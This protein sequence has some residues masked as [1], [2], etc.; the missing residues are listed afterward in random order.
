MPLPCMH[1]LIVT[2][3]LLDNTHPSLARLGTIVGVSTKQFLAVYS[4][5]SSHSGA[6]SAAANAITPMERWGHHIMG[7]NFRSSQLKYMHLS[8]SNLLYVSLAIIILRNPDNFPDER[9][10]NS[11]PFRDPHVHLTHLCRMTLV[12]KPQLSFY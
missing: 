12:M 11:K 7:S 6:A 3:L 4:S 2:I 8:C 9:V 10:P 5:H 1:G